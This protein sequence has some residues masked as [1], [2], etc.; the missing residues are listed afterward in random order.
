[1]IM[2]P[3]DQLAPLVAQYIE[4]SAVFLKYLRETGDGQ[5]TDSPMTDYANFVRPLKKAETALREW[6]K[7][8]KTDLDLTRQSPGFDPDASCEGGGVIQSARARRHYC[9]E[10]DR[11]ATGR[12]TITD[13]LNA[14]VVA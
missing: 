7:G 8:M 4:A 2:S 10:L 13:I 6:A 1:M 9:A 5:L 3:R 11:L 14:C 12:Q